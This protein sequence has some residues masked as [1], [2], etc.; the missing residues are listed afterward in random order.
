MERNSAGCHS[1]QSE[2]SARHVSTQMLHFVQHDNP[3]QL[4][5]SPLPVIFMQEAVSPH[6]IMLYYPLIKQIVF[7]L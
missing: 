2:E 7:L 6:R 4:C 5:I 1:E 3:K